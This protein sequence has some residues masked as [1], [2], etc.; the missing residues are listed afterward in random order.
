MTACAD[1]TSPE[2]QKLKTCEACGQQF[3]CKAMA[4]GCWCEEIHLTPAARE[5]I[6]RCHRDCL[7]RN[8]LSRFQPDDAHLPSEKS[9]RVR[10][11]N[12]FVSEVIARRTFQESA[13]LARTRWGPQ[14]AQGLGFDLANA[15]ACDGE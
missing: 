11:K 10:I 2:Q 6:S 4:A 9:S 1:P 14:L 7:C 5:E 3:L 13:Q 12:D 8:C 15:L